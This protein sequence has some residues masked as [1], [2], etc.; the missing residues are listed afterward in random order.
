MVMLAGV[1]S[2]VVQKIVA[3][4]VLLE[5]VFPKIN[6]QMQVEQDDQSSLPWFYLPSGHYSLRFTFAWIW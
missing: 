5:N 6:K 4:L 1:S 2:F 3:N